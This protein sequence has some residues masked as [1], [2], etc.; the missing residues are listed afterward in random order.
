MRASAI[1]DSFITCPCL[2]QAWSAVHALHSRMIHDI[3]QSF[4]RH[5]KSEYLRV[6]GIG[7]AES[8]QG[9]R[10]QGLFASARD[11]ASGVATGGRRLS[12]GLVYPPHFV[13]AGRE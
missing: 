12:H 2:P 8:S 3:F 4:K 9:D 10:L 6:V 1:D 13:N 11:R 5:P 7:S